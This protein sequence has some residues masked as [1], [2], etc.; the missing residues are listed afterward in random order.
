[1]TE[2]IRQLNAVEAER[3]LPDLVQ[4]LQGAMASGASVGYLPPLADETAGA[5]W[6]S[7][8]AA[9]ADGS[10]V[11][12]AAYHAGAVAG[13]VQLDLC[14]PPN[15]RHRAEVIKLLVHT[16]HRREGLGRTTL[17]LDTLRG[18][19]AERL[20]AAAGRVRAGVIPAFAR[21][22]DGG[23]YSRSTTT[24]CRRP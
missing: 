21:G 16:R 15:G 7:A 8:L 14:L 6:Q 11:L 10:R 20:Y 22:A 19:D 17:V 1:M 4:L 24:N 5:Y 23:L 12:L 9:T 13:S 18:N 2:D 3:A